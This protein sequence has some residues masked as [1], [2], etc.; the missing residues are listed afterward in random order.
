MSSGVNATIY[1]L[2]LVWDVTV[3]SGILAGKVALITGAGQ[4]VGLGIAQAYASAGAH[5]VI[6]G[7]DA[8]KLETSPRNCASSVPKSSRVAGDARLRATAEPTL[9]RR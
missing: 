2:P 5:L 3:T 9:P 4:G 7:R 8:A 1:S 6:T